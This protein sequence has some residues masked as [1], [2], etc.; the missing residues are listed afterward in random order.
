M[1]LVTND[2]ARGCV[3]VRWNDDICA[4]FPWAWLRDNCPS[5]FHPD[6]GERSFDLLSVAPDCQP[7]NVWLSAGD[8]MI[9]WQDENHVSRFD[10]G[11]LCNHRPGKTMDDPADIPYVAWRGDIGAAGIPRANAQDVMQGDQALLDWLRETRRTGLSIIEGLEDRLD[12]GM[13]VARRIG[14]LRETNF[15]TTFAVKSMPNPNNLAYTSEVLPLH[16]DLPNQELVPGFQ[17]LHCLANEADGGEST[18]ADGVAMAEDLRAEDAEAFGLLSTIAIPFRFQ[19]RDTDIRWRRPVIVLDDGGQ[20]TQICYNAH[21]AGVFDMDADV[22]AAYYRAYRKLMAKTR[23]PKY[24]VKLKLRGG[25]MV[26]FDNR[27]ALHGRASFDP[28]TG[29]RH[30]HGC[31]VDRGEF[32]SRMRVLARNLA[33]AQNHDPSGRLAAE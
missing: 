31:Y 27:R 6:T 23:D 15:G 22:I 3:T 26:V 20:V 29:F 7:Q 24:V 28:S 9:E 2:A 13:D 25:E 1:T 17:F 5:G 12:A 16:T 33:E 30:L 32:E 19:D 18:F 10:L 8:L 21:I 4:H 11:W 14:F